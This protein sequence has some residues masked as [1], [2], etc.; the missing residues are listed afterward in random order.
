MSVHLFV[1]TIH[2]HLY[3]RRA[4]CIKNTVLDGSL[5]RSEDHD[6]WVNYE[7]CL[8]EFSSVSTLN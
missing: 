3:F 6:F 5:F 1:L 7:S 2:A 8:G 4:I